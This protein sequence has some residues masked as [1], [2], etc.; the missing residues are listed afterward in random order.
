[1]SFTHT[2]THTWRT[3]DLNGINGS[4]SLFLA[5][6]LSHPPGGDR[7]RVGLEESGLCSAYG[8]I[9]TCIYIFIYLYIAPQIGN[10]AETREPPRD[11]E[12]R[13]GSWRASI[14][15]FHKGRRVTVF[16]MFFSYASVALSSGFM[17]P[18]RAGRGDVD[19][20]ALKEKLQ[21]SSGCFS[22]SGE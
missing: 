7:S 9:Y 8:R 12:W 18:N 22:G 14:T 10:A 6:N 4:S 1:M 3:L 21:V 15:I 11:C 16:L 13:E 17:P 2:P 19:V 20:G 5:S